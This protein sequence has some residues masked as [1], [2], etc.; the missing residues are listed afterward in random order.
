M[1]TNSILLTVKQLLGIPIEIP[2]VV[3]HV[4]W[5]ESKTETGGYELQYSTDK[6][7]DTFI[8]I[9]TKDRETEVTV[10]TKTKTY[11]RVRDYSS[12]GSKPFD[13]VHF[14]PEIDDEEV[15]PISKTND[16]EISVIKEISEVDQFDMD[17]IVGINMALNTLTQIGI[18]PETGFRITNSSQTWEEFIGDD[19]RLESVKEYVYLRTKIVFDSSTMSSIVMDAYNRTIRE[20]EWRLNVDVDLPKNEENK[21]TEGG[22]ENQNGSG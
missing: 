19:I 22:E 2:H 18:G 7:F 17:I 20:L 14:Y 5:P 3:L 9:R 4:K 21:E 10:S 12:D 8:A 13:Y 6:K 16:F 11:F 15:M 1:K